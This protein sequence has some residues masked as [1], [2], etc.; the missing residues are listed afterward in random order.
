[1]ASR[2]IYDKGIFAIVLGGSAPSLTAN[3]LEVYGVPEV[4]ALTEMLQN[5][6]FTPFG[7]RPDT[8]GKTTAEVKGVQIHFPEF[9]V[10]SSG[11]NFPPYHPVLVMCGHKPPAAVSNRTSTINEDT[12]L[13][14]DGT[15][16]TFR[17]LT[18]YAPKTF[19]HVTDGTQTATG[20]AGT[21]SGDGTGT[22]DLE[23]GLVTVTFSTAPTNGATITVRYTGGYSLSYEPS[24]YPQELDSAY[25]I[26]TKHQDDGLDE[27]K[28]L[29]SGVRGNM[30]LGLA[31]GDVLM[32]DI[33]GTGAYIERA[34]TGSAPAA[35]TYSSASDLV[36]DDTCTV[37]LYRVKDGGDGEQYVGIVPAI[38]LNPN[39]TSEEPRGAVTIGYDVEAR[40]SSGRST[41]T[42]DLQPLVA[43]ELNLEKARRL[44]HQFNFRAIVPGRSSLLNKI[45]LTARLQ[46]LEIGDA[47]RG[48]GGEEQVQVTFLIV[49]PGNPENPTESI[50]EPR[51]R[52]EVVTT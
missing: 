36:W 27:E 15:T 20:S 50:T 16:T 7:S 46:I 26:V 19:T 12:G 21:F 14:G 32:A 4:K 25:I 5:E 44:G 30:T 41:L 47:Q 39:Y 52:L 49:T 2:K 11:T 9:T 28:A 45:A 37:V 31:T 22:Y 42:L 6:S 13:R 40:L 23:T 8:P 35:P 10:A 29:T 17:F 3:A 51:Y 34:M 38:G 48:F 33:S 24:R 43:D 18:K 1:M